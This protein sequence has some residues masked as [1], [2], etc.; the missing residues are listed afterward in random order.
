MERR[1]VQAMGEKNRSMA[2][3]FDLDGTLM[4]L[5]SL[6][7]RFFRVLRY[8]KAIP[9]ENYL[10]WLK[11]A[12]RLL[13]R[14][15]NAIMQAN[16]MYLKGVHSLDE[17]DTE[18]RNH[19][20]GHKSGHQSEG[21]T[22]APSSKR[23]RRN[24]RWP[25]PLFF[26]EAVERAAWHARQGH[27]IVL[28][29]GT[30]EPLAKAAAQTLEAELALRGFAAE[31]RVCA[32]RLEEIDGRWT[33]RIAGEAM[34]GEAKARAVKKLAEEM[35]LDLARSHAYG[36]GA[37]DQWLLEAVGKP[38]AVNPSCKLAQ[39]ARKRGWPVL[40]WNEARSQTQRHSEHGEKE[41]RK[42]ERPANESLPREQP[43]EIQGRSLQAVRW[44]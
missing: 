10:L 27:A 1:E 9:A 33:G 21:Q 35:R 13:P 36:D 37:N 20:R 17:S 31:I 32:T 11:E 15:I 2:A 12:A 40:R 8:R 28:V 42:Q 18:N 6:E 3:F 19:F 23:A 29:S 4:P 5:P 24:P 22:P 43:R 39:I 44:I 30:L 26:R 7:R 25:V 14:G 38:V 41:E 34:F 16:K